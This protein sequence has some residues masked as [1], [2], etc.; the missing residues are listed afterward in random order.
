MARISNIPAKKVVD[1]SRWEGDNYILELQGVMEECSLFGNK[2]R[3]KR[4]IKTQ[5]DGKSLLITDKV[6]NF[7][8]KESPFNILYHINPGFPLLDAGTEL[9][10]S[11]RECQPEDEKSAGAIDQAKNFTAP[12]KDFAEENFLYQMLADAEGF[13]YATLINRE[14]GNGLGLYLKF[15]TDNLPLFNEWKMM[16]EGDYVVGIEPVNCRPANRAE[17]RKTGKLPFL[18]PGESKEMMVEIGVLAAQ[19]EINLFEKKIKSI[20]E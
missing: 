15:K 3:L 1:L 11:A 19:K 9:L 6:T 17:L 16:G 8:F 18:Q 12:Q 10:I 4:N 13:G 5:L 20:I 7:G 14:L 2:L